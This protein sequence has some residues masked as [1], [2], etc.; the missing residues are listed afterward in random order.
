MLLISNIVIKLS[1][2]TKNKPSKAVE[3][4][5]TA[6]SPSKVKATKYI[7]LKVW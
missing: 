6:V 3:C 5:A 4:K 2:P 1:I 7:I